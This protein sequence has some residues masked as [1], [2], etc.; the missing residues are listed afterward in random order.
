MMRMSNNAW[1][2]A[3]LLLS[4]PLLAA[5]PVPAPAIA[6]ATASSPPVSAATVPAVSGMPA[7]TAIPAPAPV[8]LPPMGFVSSVM[9]DELYAAV[10]ATPAFAAMDK[11]LPGSPLTLLITH[12]TRPTAGGQAAGLLSAILSGS[13]L[14]ILPVVSSDRVVVKYEVRLNGRPVASASFETTD[15]RA[16]N[17]WAAPGNAGGLGKDSIQ[18]LKTTAVEASDKLSRDPAMLKVMQEIEYYFPAAPGSA[19]SAAAPAVAGSASAQ[20]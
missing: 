17:I 8:V 7:T 13:T 1:L 5:E 14:G 9:S 18:W 15:T 2:L 16:Q 6:P 12:T 20:Q 19:A 3:G 10:K 4:S 11:E